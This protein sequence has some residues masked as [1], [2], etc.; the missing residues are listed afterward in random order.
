MNLLFGLHFDFIF[1]HFCLSVE[2]IGD[3]CAQWSGVNSAFCRCFANRGTGAAFKEREPLGLRF[4]E[5]LHFFYE[6]VMDQTHEGL[7]QHQVIQEDL[8]QVCI[9]A[10]SDVPKSQVLSDGV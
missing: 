5:D 1:E 4:T 6:A 8:D 3:R 7:S 9:L 10:E 2:I